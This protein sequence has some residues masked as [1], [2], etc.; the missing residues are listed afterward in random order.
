MPR[1][2]LFLVSRE[3]FEGFKKNIGKVD[4]VQGVKAKKAR[5]PLRSGDIMVL[6]AKG[7]GEPRK[8][9]GIVGELEVVEVKKVDKD[10]YEKFKK[11]GRVYEPPIPDFSGGP[12]YVKVVKAPKI[13]P[14]EVK[15]SELY[16]VKTSKSKKPIGKW[17][18]IG[19]TVIDEQAI[20][21]IRNKAESETGKQ[22]SFPLD[23]YVKDMKERMSKHPPHLWTEDDTK[24]VFIERLLKVLEW[25]TDNLDEVARRYSVKIGT[26]TEFVDYVL[27]ME[28]KPIIFVEV[29]ALGENLD[30]FEDQ[31]ISYAKVG[32]VKWAVLTN[33]R[34]LRLYDVRIRS[35]LFK[36]TL[37]DYLRERDKLL[38]LSKVSVKEGRLDEYGDKEYHKLEVMKWF[39][40]SID[41]MVD[42]IVK[43]NQTLKRE[44]VRGILE[45]MLKKI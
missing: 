35:P 3:W 15:F 9:W 14:R 38:L 13:Y 19:A 45:D 7:R 4:V 24:V 41:E 25:N 17:T 18:L 20:K 10:E 23:E 6:V 2:V 21:D 11:A 5:P 1:Y 34:E 44:I 16:D 37:D 8:N 12:I 43:T 32:D 22:P 33:G 39:K 42:K 28:G 40:E 27:K 31:A 26:K 30:P 36:L 29:K